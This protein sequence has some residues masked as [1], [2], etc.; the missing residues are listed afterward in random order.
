MKIF[1]Q[2]VYLRQ[3]LSAIALFFLL[4]GLI[5]CSGDNG[6]NNYYEY[7]AWDTAY[8]NYAN[9]ED[10]IIEITDPDFIFTIQDIQW[11]RYH[12]LGRTI[13][14]EGEF[15]SSYWEDE[16]IYFVARLEGECCGFHGFEVYL[17]EIPPFDDETWVEV[18]GILEE[19][20]LEDANQYFLRLNVITLEER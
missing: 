11:N 5:G 19:F 18:T 12:F 16:A 20:Y 10:Y 7:A 1:L 9:T 6:D 3:S 14:F 15:L 17:N 2:K 8:Q 13:R 4:L